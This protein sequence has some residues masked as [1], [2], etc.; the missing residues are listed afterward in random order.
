MGLEA[1]HAASGPRGVGLLEDF[2]VVVSA[3]EDVFDG[4]PADLSDGDG[5]F[6]DGLD[7]DAFDGDAGGHG[8]GRLG[9]DI[10]EGGAAFFLDVGVLQSLSHDSADNWIADVGDHGGSQAFNGDAVNV[11]VRFLGWAK[12]GIL[13]KGP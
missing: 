3:W 7:A 6:L 1:R 5:G 13:V 10:A 2:D 12:S 9:K 11:G 4:F 8:Q